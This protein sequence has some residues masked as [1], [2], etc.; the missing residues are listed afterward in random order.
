MKW[1]TLAALAVWAVLVP[2]AMAYASLAGVPQVRGLRDLRGAWHEVPESSY[3]VVHREGHDE[4]RPF[5]PRTPSR[6][7]AVPVG[8]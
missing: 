1:D 3:G 5:K 7:A 6:H 2:Q 8:A 4:L